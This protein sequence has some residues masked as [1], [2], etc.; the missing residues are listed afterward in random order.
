MLSTEDVKDIEQSFQALDD[1]KVGTID[2]DRFYT[3]WLGLGFDPSVSKDQIATLHVLQE[4]LD[5]I[6]LDDVLTITSR[7]SYLCTS[8][9]HVFC[10]C[11]KR[12]TSSS[13]V[14]YSRDRPSE[15]SCSFRLLDRDGKESITAPDL[16]IL[17]K[18]MGE[19]LLQEEAQAM[20]GDK[21]YWTIDDLRAVLS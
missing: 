10:L 20:L 18:E 4:R 6:T 21:D 14:Q 15:L 13:I 16:V 9:K 17:A 19:S 12:L 5:F 1:A 8:W 3:L 11:V 2:I 7:V